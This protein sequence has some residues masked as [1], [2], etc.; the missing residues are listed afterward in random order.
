M[1]GKLCM[2]NPS[3]TFGYLNSYSYWVLMINWCCLSKLSRFHWVAD[4]LSAKGYRLRCP[5]RYCRSLNP[6]FSK[7]VVVARFDTCM[8]RVRHYYTS[9]YI[10][11][12]YSDN[13][14]WTAITLVSLFHHTTV[15]L[16]YSSHQRCRTVIAK[17]NNLLLKSIA[18]GSN[19]I[20]N[21]LLLFTVLN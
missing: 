4:V 11:S 16:F 8:I 2:S 6:I 13:V 1:V 12:S 20:L 10:V 18:K 9:S 19:T 15:K 14:S 7:L 3:I 17:N 21:F 5:F